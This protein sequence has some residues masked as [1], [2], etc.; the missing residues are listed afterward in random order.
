VTGGH[1]LTQPKYR[2][3]IDGLRGIAVLAV[4]GYHAYPLAIRGGF[5]GVDVFFVISG[6]LISNILFSNL[7][8]NNF[9]YA[10]FYSRR[11][12]R[13]FPALI[14]ILMF[15]LIL[16]WFL[17]PTEF[18]RIGKHVAAGAGFV[19]NF[20]FW[21][22]AGY[23]DSSAEKKPLLHLWSLGIEEQFYI[24]WPLL[25]GICWR[26]KWNFLKVTLLIAFASFAA[27]LYLVHSNPIAAFYSPIPRFWEL[28]LG[29]VL[30]YLAL[31]RLQ[32]LPQNATWPSIVGC[33]LI[34]AGIV[35]TS[36]ENPFPGW[37]ALLPTVGT[38]LAIA[39]GPHSWVNQEILAN[40]KLVWIGLISY[41]LYLWHWPIL[42]I[43]R[44]FFLYRLKG[45]RAAAVI[46][47]AIALSFLLSWLTYKLV[48]SP[49]RFGSL[50]KRA[51]PPLLATMAFL[52]VAGILV[53]RTNGFASR[54]SP[55]IVAILNVD[56]QRTAAD[57]YNEGTCFLRREQGISSFANCTSQTAA[58]PSQSILLW[59]DSHAAHLY[60]GLRHELGP[61]TQLT[62]FT[63][64]SCPPI[65]GYTSKGWRHCKEINDYVMAYILE[66]HPDRVILAAAWTHYDWMTLESTIQQLKQ[67]GVREIDLVGPV[68]LWSESLPS[69]LFAYSLK[70]PADPTVP[71]RMSFGLVPNVAQLDHSMQQFTEQQGI[72]YISPYQILC[73]ADGCLTLAANSP[74]SLTMWDDSHLTIA[75]SRFVVSQFDQSRKPTTPVAP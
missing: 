36:N 23:F 62:Q 1:Q 48:E 11:I 60:P 15:C 5:V 51:V 41:P 37:W 12:K 4:I 40:R 58:P 49:I 2:S 28:M 53:H 29:G 26:R 38:F 50:K 20:D 3:D 57:S 27:N 75:G 14:V 30:A 64:A 69:V 70:H 16:G 74:D 35:L 19:S 10:E 22:E 24:F 9:S 55:Q 33:L 17:L 25:L 46:F 45:L 63:A 44:R 31:H 71:I 72:R 7:E 54:F 59:G 61:S 18:S 68:P 73:N 66:E 21:R 43:A 47:S 32:H 67:A 6:F 13:I 65:L 34:A 56:Y 42:F 52:I 39:A 8:N